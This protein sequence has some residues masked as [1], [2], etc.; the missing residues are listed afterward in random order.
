MTEALLLV[1]CESLLKMNML[2]V[3]ILILVIV[4]AVAYHNSKPNAAKTSC[5]RVPTLKK[6]S[7]YIL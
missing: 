2:I 5:L 4:V 3:L 7:S 1:V 6:E